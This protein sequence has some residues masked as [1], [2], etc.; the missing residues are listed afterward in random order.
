MKKREFLPGRRGVDRATQSMDTV[1]LNFAMLSSRNVCQ[2]RQICCII[3]RTCCN[4]RV[5][6]LRCLL[7]CRHIDVG[8]SQYHCIILL[9]HIYKA[10]LKMP[11]K[12]GHIIPIDFLRP[13]YTVFVQFIQNIHKY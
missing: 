11:L 10:Q 6:L 13:S 9:V 1:R 5:I 12:L 2:R 8:P 4:N 7:L 3:V